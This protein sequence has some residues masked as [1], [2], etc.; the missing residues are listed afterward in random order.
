MRKKTALII[1]IVALML[2]TADALITNWMISRVSPD[3]KPMMELNPIMVGIAGTPWL[4][5]VKV[6]WV[7]TFILAVIFFKDRQLK[8]EI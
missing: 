5:V 3:I 7:I 1:L 2:V 8:R 6:G 4:V